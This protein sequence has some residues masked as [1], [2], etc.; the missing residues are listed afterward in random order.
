VGLCIAH[1]VYLRE[2]YNRGDLQLE[3]VGSSVDIMGIISPKPLKVG[4]LTFNFYG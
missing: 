1:D 3:A 4:N 2:V